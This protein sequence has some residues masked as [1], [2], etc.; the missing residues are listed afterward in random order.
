[1]TVAIT[2]AGGQFGRIVVEQ[3]LDRGFPAEQIIAGTRNTERL[4][5]LADR[6]VDVRRID[7]DDPTTLQSGLAGAGKVLIVSGVDFGRRVEQHTAAARAAI[8]A[9]AGLV[10]Y[11]SAPY[12][13]TTPMM[14]AAEH[15]GT[16]ESIRSLGVPFT[17]LRNS[18]YFENYTAQLATYLEHGA[19]LGSA[20]DGRI[21]GAARADYAAA[22]AAV[23][24]SDGHERRVYELGGDESFTLAELAAT[25]ST[26]SGKNVGYVDLAPEAF[27]Q[28]LEGA[29]LPPQMAAMFA[30]VDVAIAQ[31]KLHVETGDLSRLIGRPPTSLAEAVRSALS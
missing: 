12:A 16:E 6:G 28:A 25:I 4:S 23:L 14:L 22:A 7:F 10:L 29:G 24:A 19:V 18:W 3:L 15:R 2:G 17:F 20:G 30:D 1:M 5:D 27:Q 21:S 31:G 13:D 8:D 26:E 11:T 9:G